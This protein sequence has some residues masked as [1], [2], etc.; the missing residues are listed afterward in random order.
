M[1][2]EILAEF[3]AQLEAVR[4]LPTTGGVYEVTLDGALVYSKLATG[5]HA[6]AGEVL[7]LLRGKLRH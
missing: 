1:V 6:E 2:V 7:E 3:E 4:L 5:R